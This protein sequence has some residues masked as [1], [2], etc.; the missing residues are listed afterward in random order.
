VAAALLAPGV[1]SAFGQIGAIIGG[2]LIGWW[3]IEPTAVRESAPFSVR[4]APTSAIV[5]LALFFV[6]LFG[7]PVIVSASH[8]HL[9]ALISSFYRSGALVFGGGHVVLP[10]LQ[11]AV[12]PPGWVGNDAFLA[13]YGAAQPF[14]A[15]LPITH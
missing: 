13:G 10:L 6:L 8:N 14:R 7:L 5:A 1:P 3:M 4:I 11:Q 15:T 2:G 12:V 9:I